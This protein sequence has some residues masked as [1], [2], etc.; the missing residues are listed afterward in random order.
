M[1]R[2]RF[3]AVQSFL[4]LQSLSL[5]D[6]CYD[7]RHEARMTR[8]THLFYLPYENKVLFTDLCTCGQLLDFWVFQPSDSPDITLVAQLS[9]DRL[10]MIEPLYKHWEG[11]SRECCCLCVSVALEVVDI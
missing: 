11:M 1:E 3:L 8:R 6:K 7:F 9:V 5:D 4:L 10:Q 2:E